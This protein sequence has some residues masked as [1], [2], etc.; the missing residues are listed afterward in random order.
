[1]KSTDFMILRSY[2]RDMKTAIALEP[3]Q[4]DAIVEAF[5]KQGDRR[6][7]VLSMLCGSRAMRI[8][9]VL[10]LTITDLFHGSEVRKDL[11]IK[12]RKTLHKSKP[13]RVIPLWSEGTEPLKAALDAFYA[14]TLKGLPVTSPLFVNAKR[15]ITLTRQGVAKKLKEMVGLVDIES[16]QANPHGLRKYAGRRMFKAGIPIET[17]SKVYFHGPKGMGDPVTTMAYLSIKPA[18]VQAAWNMLMA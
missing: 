14:E 18:E 6:M 10:S 11:R 4:F 9:D 2:I 17:I 3:N 13:E 15:G 1:M 12:E 7:Q 5:E 16:R 8:G